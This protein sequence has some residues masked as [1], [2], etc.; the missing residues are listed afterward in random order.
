MHTGHE[1]HWLAGH[2][3]AGATQSL[4]R[5]AKREENLRAQIIPSAHW[6]IPLTL[7]TLGSCGLCRETQT[8]LL[9]TSVCVGTLRS[10]SWN[11]TPSFL[12]SSATPFP[13]NI[14]K[15]DDSVTLGGKKSPKNV[16]DKKY[17]VGYNFW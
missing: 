8:A 12:G 6:H 5:E 11:Q 1:D 3:A 2:W 16:K 9:S 13:K 10:F 7:G 15:K 14:C 17:K 4:F